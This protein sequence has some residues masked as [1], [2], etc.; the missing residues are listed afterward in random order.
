MFPI[1]TAGTMAAGAATGSIA[2]EF[3]AVHASESTRGVGSGPTLIPGVNGGQE[4]DRD[5]HVVV[6][7]IPTSSPY[8]RE[9]LEN[10]FHPYSR[11]FV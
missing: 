7:L 2:Q 6:Q 1:P 11:C 4:F 10:S 9:A 8:E 3:S 5:L